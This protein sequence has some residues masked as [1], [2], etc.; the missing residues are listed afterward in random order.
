MGWLFFC[1]NFAH[2]EYPTWSQLAP[3]YNQFQKIFVTF[4]TLSHNRFCKKNRICTFFS[5][6]FVTNVTKVWQTEKVW[7]N[8]SP[9]HNRAENRTFYTR[10]PAFCHIFKVWQNVTRPASLSLILCERKFD[11]KQVPIRLSFCQ[12]RRTLMLPPYVLPFLCRFLLIDACFYDKIKTSCT[13]D[14]PAG[15]IRERKMPCDAQEGYSRYGN[16]EQ[17]TRS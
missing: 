13:R 9:S 10:N 11:L 7:R 17:R 6:I 4:V 2:S 5:K 3:E 15:S 1:P 8:S 16:A 12:L 14:A